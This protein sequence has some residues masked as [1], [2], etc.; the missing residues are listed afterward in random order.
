MAVD[1]VVRFLLGGTIVTLF[2]LIG[3]LVKPKTFAGLFGSAPSVAIVSLTL[4]F[5]KH[6][7]AHVA[8]ET[9]TMLLGA[10]G[11]LAYCAICVVIARKEKAIWIGAVMAWALWACVAFGAFAAARAIGAPL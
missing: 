9:R 6:G 4:A 2:A 7:R 5:E 11:L 1:L 10:L 3:E 8:E